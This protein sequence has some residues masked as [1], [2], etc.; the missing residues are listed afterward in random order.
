MTESDYRHSFDQASH[1]FELIRRQARERQAVLDER[2][3]EI[4][5]D[6]TSPDGTVSVSVNADGGLTGIRFTDAISAMSPTDLEASIM[7][8]YDLAQRRAAHEAAEALRPV[9]GDSGYLQ[10][11]FRQRQESM[12]VVEDSAADDRPAVSTIDGDDDDFDFNLMRG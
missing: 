4:S 9:F 10:D 1:Y 12:A 7:R 3:P 8:T 5:A 11:R 6:A 2:L